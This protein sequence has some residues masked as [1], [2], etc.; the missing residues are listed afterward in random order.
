VILYGPPGTGKTFWAERAARD[1]AA[2]RAF[3]QPFDVLDQAGQETVAGGL[4]GTG[5]VRLCCFHPAYGYE[6]FIE[7]YRPEAVNGQLSFRL[8]D[9]LFKRLCAD[10]TRTPDRNYYL[11]IDEINR[12]NVAR[13]FGELLQWSINLLYGR[14]DVAHWAHIA[15]TCR[16]SKLI[17]HGWPRD[18]RFDSLAGVRDLIAG[19]NAAK[20]AVRVNLTAPAEG[21]VALVGVTLSQF[22]PAR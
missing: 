15:R 5:L 19:C 3:G 2:Y 16:C 20:L 1:L 22:A 12:G 18:P 10:A 9:G 17:W 21:M 8:R 7:G 11:I 6:D 14:E 4:Q 13:I